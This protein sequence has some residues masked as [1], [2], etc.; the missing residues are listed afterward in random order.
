LE[1][2]KD[3]QEIDDV[4]SKE[5]FGREEESNQSGSTYSKHSLQE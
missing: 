2:N 5:T 3:S 1:P 4:L